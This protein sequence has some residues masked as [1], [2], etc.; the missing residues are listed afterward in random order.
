M[1]PTSAP[2]GPPKAKPVATDAL[3]GVYGGVQGIDTIN[4]ISLSLFAAASGDIDMGGNQVSKIAATPKASDDAASKAYVDLVATGSGALI[5]QGG[6]DAASNSPVLDDRAGAT[7]IAVLKGWTYAV[8]SKGTFYGEV[9][10]DGDLL[11]AEIDNAKHAS[12]EAKD[13]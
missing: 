3:A 4:N 12:I 13:T 10:E 9:V 7:P 6:Y 11:I 5:F 1:P 8:T 2:I